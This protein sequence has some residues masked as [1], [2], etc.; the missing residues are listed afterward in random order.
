M[1]HVT[2]PTEWVLEVGWQHEAIGTHGRMFE[3]GH[4]DV[5]YHSG[6]AVYQSSLYTVSLFTIP[7]NWVNPNGTMHGMFAF[8]TNGP[9]SL[10]C[11]AIV[12]SMKL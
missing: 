5:P 4:E 9:G 10:P 8:H 6:R 11:P 1:S 2:I 3:G 12:Y 7:T